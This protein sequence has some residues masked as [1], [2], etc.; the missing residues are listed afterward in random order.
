MGKPEPLEEARRGREQQRDEEGDHHVDDDGADGP[1]PD[2]EGR[3]EVDQTD[4]DGHRDHDR[5]QRDATTLGAAGEPGAPGGGSL[6]GHGAQLGSSDL[7]RGAFSAVSRASMSAMDEGDQAD[8]EVEPSPGS[9][10]D[11]GTEPAPARRSWL[12]RNVK[13]T[14]M[15]LFLFFVG[16]YVLLP[17]LASARREAHQLSHLNFLWLVLGVLLE[18]AASGRLLRAH[19]HRPLPRRAAAVACLPHQHVGARRQPRAARAAPCRGRRPAT[20]CS[21]SP[22]CRAARPPSGWPPRASGRPSCSTSSSGSRCSSPSRSRA[23]TRSTASPPSWASC[24][25]RSSPGSCSSS[26]G[27]RSRRPRSS[28]GW[29]SGCRSCGP[30]SVTSLVQK[31]ADRMKILFSSSELLTRAVHLGH[32][33]LAARR[34]LALGLPPRFRRPH[35]ADRC[36]RGLRAGEHPRLHPGHPERPRRH[37]ADHRGRAHALRR[38]RRC[39]GGGRAQLA[40]RQLLAPDPLRWRLLP[41]APLEPRAR[42]RAA[43]A[44]TRS[45]PEPRPARCARDDL[46]RPPVGS[47]P[48][49]AAW[50]EPAR[51]PRMGSPRQSSPS[52]VTC[53][54]WSPCR[55]A[56]GPDW[57]SGRAS[58]TP[59]WHGPSGTGW[60]RSCCSA[61]AT[62]PGPTASVA[63]RRGGSRSTTPTR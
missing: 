13:I 41:L 2:D 7:R 62:T 16:E 40:P 45:P 8:P 33:Q 29:R 59:R 37:R 26:P 49:A 15:V 5:G 14:L 44:P 54:A 23:T 63:A 18:V 25:W 39:G 52:I 1:E 36:A 19:A 30:E 6:V 20:G 35:L 61:P 46:Q 4:H 53:A 3:V 60:T 58:S 55:S 42:A 22:T 43:R 24:S 48:S 12:P 31:V 47:R 56:P 27:A 28:A 51:R 38:R 11:G 10:P 9:V 34:R 21:P 57:T 50:R 32:G 17:E